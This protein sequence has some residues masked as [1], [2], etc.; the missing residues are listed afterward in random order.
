MENNF[1][2]RLHF[3]PRP[4]L[5]SV[6]VLCHFLSP[7]KYSPVLFYFHLVVIKCSLCKGKQKSKVD[8]SKRKIL[9][10]ELN[11]LTYFNTE[12]WRMRVSIPLPRAC[13]ARALPFELIPLYASSRNNKLF[14]KNLL[15]QLYCKIETARDSFFL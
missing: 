12:K 1:K 5:G 14:L 8:T 11:I 6:N 9:R 13:K 2:V 7:R 15:V 3:V 10:W 4:L